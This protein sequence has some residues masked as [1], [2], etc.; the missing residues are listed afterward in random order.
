[1]F[2]RRNS[3]GA[4]AN[5]K[6]MTFPE[7]TIDR[8]QTEIS[9]GRILLNVGIAGLAFVL[10]CAGLNAF[11]PFPEID[12]VSPNLR[13]LLQHRDDF[14]T[15]FIGSSRIRHQISPAIFDRT[16]GAAGL[17]TRTFNFGIN[18]MVPPEDSYVLERFLGARPRHLRWVFIELD[19]LQTE[20]V[21][22]TEGTRR[23][24]YWHDGKRTALVLRAILDPSYRDSGFARLRKL[25]E[26]ML[27]GLENSEARDLFFFHSALFAK[28]F[29][30]IG[31]K[32]ELAGWI[33]R[34]WKEEGLSRE[35][36]SNGYVPLS[37][38]M[39]AAEAVI[40]QTEIERAVTHAGSRSVSASTEHAYREL[41][42]QVR[43]A[44]ATPIFLV[45]PLTMQVKLEFRS[46]SGTGATVMSFNNATAYPQLYRNEMRIDRSHLNSA[47]AEEFTR[48]VA[49][50]FLQLRRENRIQ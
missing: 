24:L 31:R 44:G 17:P 41:A 25:G 27:P 33:S 4:R 13:F 49:E 12:V 45:T 8:P 35:L 19:E 21:P 46:E 15:I 40:Y 10:A 26:L 22:E 3:S 47:A 6:V 43:K 5:R 30:N 28:K 39:S 20:R 48:L 11:L 32:I 37:Q 1:V 7:T 2:S 16:M 34:L 29:T 50:N 23:A 14:D 18:G 36:G 42:E 38:T 9:P